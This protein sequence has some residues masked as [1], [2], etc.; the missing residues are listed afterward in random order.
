VTRAQ[1]IVAVLYC[2]L[3]VYCGVWLPWHWS[4]AGEMEDVK[5]G[6]ALVWNGPPEGYGVP[7]MAAVAARVLAATGLCAAAFLLAGRWKVLLLVPAVAGAGILLYG[8]WTDRVAARQEREKQRETQRIHDCAV[9]RAAARC[10]PYRNWELCNRDNPDD[11]KTPEEAI[12]AAETECTA[13]TDQRKSAREQIEDHRHQRGISPAATPQSKAVLA[14][15]QGG[16]F[17]QV[18]GE[19]SAGT[20]S[21]IKRAAQ[22][23]ALS[24]SV[25]GT[26][27]TPQYEVVD[28]PA[29]QFEVV[30]GPTTPSPVKRAARSSHVGKRAALELHD[31]VT[32]GEKK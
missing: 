25:G 4:V 8:Y 10:T 16:I 27:S 12:S 19:S 3:I 9:A 23:N 6:Y 24:N 31:P 28:G 21:P 14:S 29:P 26:V 7:D 20:H 22:A 18:A 30:D 13:E 17:G 2:V 5:E 15:P 11:L 1:R 32:T